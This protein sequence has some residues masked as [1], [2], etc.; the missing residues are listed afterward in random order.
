[1]KRTVAVLWHAAHR[2]RTST[3]Q[4]DSYAEVWR[5]EGHRVVHLYGTAEFV[6]ADLLI[7]H[8]DLSV[9][10]AEYLEFARRY[11]RA[12]NAGVRDIRKATF[13]TLRVTRADGYR[14]T[15]IV[16]SNLNYAGV[17]ER[18]LRAPTAP[19]GRF[20]AGMRSPQD[21][22]I[23]E[24][25]AAVP[26]DVWNDPEVIVERF[27]PEMDSGLYVTRA[28]VFLGDRVTCAKFCGPHPVVNTATSTRMDRVEPH[29]DMLALR[30]AMGFDY[31]K[32]DYVLRDGRPVLLDANKTVGGRNP[33][34]TPERIAAR[35]YR[36]EG[37]WSYFPAE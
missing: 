35:R 14:G 25:A 29:P 36:A 12:L 11:P 8:V 16:K 15:V 18:V 7:V 17:P 6:P 23:F 13:S 3:W 4:I 21:Y 33:P 24:T 19:R 9:V 10:P 20:V 5:E 2:A 26:E 1:M 28:M 32:F 34:T 37:L 22:R 27:A 30:V 31:G